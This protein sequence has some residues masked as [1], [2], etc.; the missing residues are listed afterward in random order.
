M[1]T[2]SPAPT[3]ARARTHTRICGGEYILFDSVH[4]G[5]ETREEFYFQNAIHDID[6]LSEVSP[7]QYYLFLQARPY[8]ILS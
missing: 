6:T 4:R 5:E 3:H 8:R 1:L 7:V 2:L